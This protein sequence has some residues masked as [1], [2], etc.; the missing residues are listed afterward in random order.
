MSTDHFVPAL[1]ERDLAEGKMRAVRVKGKP[2]LVAKV[3][4][5]VFGVSN[6]CPHA[7]CQFHGGILSGYILMCPCHGWKFDLRN[8]HFQDNPQTALTCYR[9]KVE[10][11]KIFVEIPK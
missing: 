9:C 2:I 7:G 1:K 5:Q 11:G 6:I 3:G 4:G 8:G 10:N